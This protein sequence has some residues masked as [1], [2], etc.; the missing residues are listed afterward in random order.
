MT[1][2]M[3]DDSDD[4]GRRQRMTTLMITDRDKS[5]D[6]TDRNRA[7]SKNKR[8]ADLSLSQAVA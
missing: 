2:T 3:V 4:R 5:N 1:V 7:K 8:T 6:R